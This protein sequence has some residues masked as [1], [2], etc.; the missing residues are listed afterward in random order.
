MGDFEE[1]QSRLAQRVARHLAEGTLV[2]EASNP[3]G[4]FAHPTKY[5]LHWYRIVAHKLGEPGPLVE[6]DRYSGVRPMGYP[7][8]GFYAKM[9]DA[10]CHADA[11]H[12]ARIA[13]GFP[14]LAVAWAA[15][16]DGALQRLLTDSLGRDST[17]P[18]RD[19][20][21]AKI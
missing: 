16:F 13:K 11:T 3:D 5:Q 12:K 8:G 20:G 2:S 19:D 21:D 18:W 17:Y 1:T 9:I 4:L 6:G 7:P 14:E 15:W 10:Y